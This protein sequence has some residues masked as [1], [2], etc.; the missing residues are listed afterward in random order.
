[1]PAYPGCPGQNPEG[2]ETVVVVVVVLSVRRQTD[3]L[4]VDC[5]RVV[6]QQL[7][8]S[9]QFFVHVASAS[10]SVLL[11]QRCDTLCTSGFVDGIMFPYN[12]SVSIPKQQ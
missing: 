2:R 5:F 9:R 4:Q 6:V 11:W 1:M 7:R 12:G 10:G 8:I 3:C